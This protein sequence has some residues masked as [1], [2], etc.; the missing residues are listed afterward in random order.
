MNAIYW[1]RVIYFEL[2]ANKLRPHLIH[3]LNNGT[4]SGTLMHLMHFVS[5]GQTRIYGLNELAKITSANRTCSF[6]CFTS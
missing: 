6:A 3:Y 4:D 5:L 2:K 1:I